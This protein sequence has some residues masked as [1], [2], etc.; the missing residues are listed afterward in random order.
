MGAVLV[1]C[2]GVFAAMPFWIKA[3][4]EHSMTTQAKPLLGHQ[5]MRGAY[6]NSGS[7]D[8]GADPDWVNEDGK[9]LYKGKSMKNFD[10]S[11]EDVRAARARLEERRR[12]MGLAAG[13]GQLPSDG[14]GEAGR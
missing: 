9:L 1:G 13:G 10:P 5:I 6:I 12:R 4:S 8:I 7:K 14:A 2:A 3:T 11:D